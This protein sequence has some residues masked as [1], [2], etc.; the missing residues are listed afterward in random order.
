MGSRSVSSL[1]R[2]VWLLLLLVAPGFSQ[3]AITT[4][5]GRDWLSSCEGRAA[6][7]CALS[8]V[9]RIAVDQQ[10]NLYIADESNHV[11]LKVDRRN[12][13]TIF[14]GNGIRGFSG[15]GGPATNASLSSPSAVT[16][17]RAGNLLV[18]DGFNYR[19]RRVTP[20][21]V[22]TTIA[23]T[24]TN[25]VEGDGGAA[26][27][28]SFVYTHDLALDAAGN[29]YVAQAD[30]N[31]VR[32][33]DTNGMVTTVAGTG[34]AGFSG[35]EGPAVRAALNFPRGLAFDRSGNLHISDSRNNR[36]RQVTSDGRISTVA[37]DGV[38]DFRGDRGPARRASLKLPYGLAFDIFGSLYIS[39]V[40]NNRIRKVTPDG[41]IDTVS[42]TGGQLFSGDGLAPDRASLFFPDGLAFEPDGSLLVADSGNVRV[43]RLRFGGTV[44]TVIGNGPFWRIDD[45]V[46]TSEVYLRRPTGLAMDAAGNLYVADADNHVVDRLDPG[47]K[48]RHSAGIGIPAFG[49]GPAARDAALSSPTGVAVAPNGDVYVVQQTDLVFRIAADGRFFR[50]A[51]TGARGFGGDG[52]PGTAALLNRPTGV[53]VDRY[54][55]LYIADTDNHRVRRVG[56]GTITTLIGNGQAGSG[57][58]GGQ[59][60]QASLNEPVAV[61]VDG[62][63]NVYVGEFLGGAIRKVTPA[64]VISTVASGLGRVQALALDRAGNL[65]FSEADTHRVRR[66]AQDGSIE[67]VAGSGGPGYAGDGGPA[68]SAAMNVPWGL[69]VD[70][71]GV[72]YIADSENHR[73]REVLVSPASYE[74]APGQ[75]SFT[76]D[77]G[78]GVSGEQVVALTGFLQGV[79]SPGIPFSASSA[80]PW[81]EVT[82]RSGVMPATLRASVNPASLA[83]GSYRG[84]ITIAVSGAGLRTVPVSLLV[85]DS[86][87][88]RLGLDVSALSFAALQGAETATRQLTVNNQGSGSLAFTVAA[89]TEVGAGWLSVSPDRGVATPGT[90]VSL[91]VTV[92]SQPLEVGT[93]TGTVRITA[94]E[95]IG[96]IKVN[97]TVSAGQQVILIS[98]TGL[99]FTAVAQG[100]A[101]LPQTV[102]VLNVGQGV[103]NWTAQT[104]TLSGG[105]SWLTLSSRSGRVARPYLDYSL[106]E[107][108]IN[109]AGL[110]P[111]DYYGKVEVRAT[112]AENSPQVVSVVLNVLQPGTNP[113]P[114]VRP[115]GLIF[116]GVPGST[117]GSQAVSVANL[118]GRA[119]FFNSVGVTLDGRNWLTHVP[120]SATIDPQ[121]PERVVVQADLRGLEPGIR[122]GAVTLLFEDGSS[123]TV[124]ILTVVAPA[125]TAALLAD[126]EGGGA[127]QRSCAGRLLVHFRSPGE[128]FVASLGQPLGLEVKVVDECGN[129]LTG[130]GA[131]A[132]V[133]AKFSN[134][135]QD[136]P[137]VHTREGLWSGT[138]LPREGREARVRIA[139][140]A[141]ATLN[142]QLRLFGQTEPLL[143]GTLQPGASTPVLARA[144][145]ANGASFATQAPV[146]PGSWVS[147]FGARLADGRTVASST[148]LDRELG[149]TEVVLGGR[150]LPLL[151]ASEGQLNAQIPYDLPVNTQHQLLVRRRT[152]LSVPEVITVAAAQP[153]I[154]SKDQS[155][156]GQ[157]VIVHG[158]TQEL[159]ESGRPAAVGE[160]VVIYCAGLGAVN[161][162]VDAGVPAP[163]SPLSRTVR[164]V[165]VTIGG[166]PA[167]VEFAGLTP[168]YAGLY[169]IN[170]VVP[171]GTARGDAVPVRVTVAGQ[172]SP[173][174]VTM[175]VQ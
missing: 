88:P 39:D 131:A 15:D 100:G 155:G 154:F 164:T 126:E 19:I 144:A 84:A 166:Q 118:L 140:Q 37:G 169:Q 86:R 3:R 73:L 135:D 20:E 52:G 149:G 50:V 130:V 69:A 111:G 119:L 123:R 152:A 54:G 99:T 18:A 71:S 137:L 139:V 128:G 160:V 58:D 109:A 7:D 159:A 114:E 31:R 147:V 48:V 94:N 36:V 49:G 162:P 121:R 63:D 42:G 136:V 41:M 148:P 60:L 102:G 67:T 70:A 105:A 24:G 168:G 82:P 145:V 167:R 143:S 79:A 170:A 117:P 171:D 141:V 172:T 93:Y 124:N 81:L 89:A 98:Q 23:G 72:L 138:W 91:T 29:L 44:S 28:A 59:A 76:A 34:Q 112:G 153:A 108:G 14:A 56:G 33:I 150:P 61:V 1:V 12:V 51:G 92:N 26:L 115:T 163:T 27:N 30:G 120:K 134:G 10:G 46:R 62:A 96:E 158:Q 80:E 16:V 103:M 4:L 110:A 132:S 127:P 38:R 17:D 68:A 45:T 57:G 106:V 87:P 175:A 97:L 161:P 8:R 47:G 65:Y 129:K 107:I 22:I 165:Q 85:R 21:G 53:A 90:P 74:V 64:G 25:G 78:A 173:L 35:D 83:P 66:L 122:R 13:V 156:R 43:R 104:T 55:N 101:V 174:G 77:S 5:A 2:I 9:R 125:G 11:V 142:P 95:D 32:R 75:L 146:A 116:T 157:G 40:D 113:G 133:Q 6:A 151:F